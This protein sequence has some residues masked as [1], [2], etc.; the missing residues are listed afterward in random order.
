MHYIYHIYL[1]HIPLWNAF[2]LNI[3]VKCIVFNPL[4]FAFQALSQLQNNNNE[5]EKSK[6]LRFPNNGFTLCH[7]AQK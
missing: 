3:D 7:K 6:Y 5:H 4:W 1:I 2:L